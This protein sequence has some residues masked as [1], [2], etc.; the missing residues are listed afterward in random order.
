MGERE[1]QGGSACEGG[2]GQRESSALPVEH[3]A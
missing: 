1:N 3:R 2:E